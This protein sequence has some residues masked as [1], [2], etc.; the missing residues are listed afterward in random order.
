MAE[1]TK[2]DP[3][4][5]GPRST[6]RILVLPSALI[7]E[8]DAREPAGCKLLDA[9]THEEVRLPMTAMQFTMVAGEP[10]RLHIEM[11][12]I[13]LR[14]KAHHVFYEIS[15]ENLRALARMNGFSIAVVPAYPARVISYGPAEC[16]VVFRDFPE[17][18][19]THQ[20]RYVRDA[21]AK[22]EGAL[23]DYL[24][25]CVDSSFGDLPTPSELE[26]G[27]VLVFAHQPADEQVDF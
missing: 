23:H 16:Q 2:P 5:H 3:I 6:E 18:V 26:E 12:E 17:L 27:E 8:G 1:E 20:N 11:G 10:N 21:L 19:V 24:R 7:L 22:A 9:S 15:E 4:V 13:A 14:A 25:D